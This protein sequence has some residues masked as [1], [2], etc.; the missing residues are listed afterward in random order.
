MGLTEMIVSVVESALADHELAARTFGS[1]NNRDQDFVA[2]ICSLGNALPLTQWSFA[3]AKS[4]SGRTSP[5]E[6]RIGHVS[7]CS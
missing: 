1:A 7:S 4:T 2:M 3:T 5:V 6:T